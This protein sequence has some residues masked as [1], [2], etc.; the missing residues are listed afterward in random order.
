MQPP[1]LREGRQPQALKEERVHLLP[2]FKEGELAGGASS[3]LSRRRERVATPYCAR[4]R[5]RV[6][7]PSPLEEGRGCP[8]ALE[9]GR[10][11]PH[12]V[13]LE[14]VRGCYLVS[15][16]ERSAERR[17]RERM[18]TLASSRRVRMTTTA[19]RRRERLPLP[20]QKRGEAKRQ[21]AEPRGKVPGEQ[22][23][24]ARGQRPGAGGMGWWGRG[25]G[26]EVRGAEGRCPGPRA[27]GRG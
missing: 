2:S 13:H 25:Q 17:S 22:R 6:A 7:T 10:G 8:A 9:D 27:R 26:P 16:E 19:S 23:Q 20:L 1:S 4:R 14:G 11:W 12:P 24:G 5:E 3:C 18:A 21:G 15:R